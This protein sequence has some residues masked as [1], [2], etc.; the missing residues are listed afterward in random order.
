[1]RR[2][3]CREH[4]SHDRLFF[5]CSWNR[6]RAISK[7][8]QKGS[9]SGGSTRAHRGIGVKEQFAQRK[10]PSL[11]LTRGVGAFRVVHLAAGEGGIER[12]DQAHPRSRKQP[13]PIVVVECVERTGPQLMHGASRQVLQSSPRP[14]GHSTPRRPSLRWSRG[15][16]PSTLSISGERNRAQTCNLGLVTAALFPLRFPGHPVAEPAESALELVG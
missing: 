4:G 13:V 10:P 11:P 5:K 12:S 3:G 15:Q 8:G 6:P 14:Q 1:M 9:C 2:I 16:T 7:C